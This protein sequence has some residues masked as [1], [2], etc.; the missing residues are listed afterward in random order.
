[1]KAP[2]RKG[3][4]LRG[5]QRLEFGCTVSRV[6]RGSSPCTATKFPREFARLRGAVPLADYLNPITRGAGGVGERLRNR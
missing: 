3:L 6:F 5:C 1:V 4:Y 2:A